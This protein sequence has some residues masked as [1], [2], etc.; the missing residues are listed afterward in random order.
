M[1]RQV[2]IEK[3]KRE[4]TGQIQ[5]NNQLSGADGLKLFGPARHR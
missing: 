3:E 4:R 1:D 5:M 2:E